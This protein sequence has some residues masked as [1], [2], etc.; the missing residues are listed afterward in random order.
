MRRFSAVGTPSLTAFRGAGVFDGPSLSSSL[1][2]T[3]RF[4]L[5]DA[6]DDTDDNGHVL[7]TSL[8]L[9][10]AR[11]GDK[12]EEMEMQEEEEEEKEVAADM[13]DADDNDDRAS[14]STDVIDD[15]NF[16]VNKR[17]IL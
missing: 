8:I 16:D 9:P 10:G 7:G 1:H 3:A 6:M 5:R 2:S 13:N 4:D 17:F 12:K 15:D 14:V 11:A